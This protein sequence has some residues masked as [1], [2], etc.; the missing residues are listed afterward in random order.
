MVDSHTYIF[1]LTNL[2][3]TG[4]HKPGIFIVLEGEKKC[5][6]VDMRGQTTLTL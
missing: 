3:K 4:G 5:I 2:R 6:F 1:Y